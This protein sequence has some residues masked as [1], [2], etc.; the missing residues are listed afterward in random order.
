MGLARQPA[1]RR[2]KHNRHITYRYFV[3]LFHLVTALHPRILLDRHVDRRGVSHV[4][5][6]ASVW[7]QVIFDIVLCD[8]RHPNPNIGELQIEVLEIR[9]VGFD[10][11]VCSYHLFHVHI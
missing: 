9:I 1:V 11:R 5:D 10:Y 2:T 8:L 6:S 7:A 3:G 4:P